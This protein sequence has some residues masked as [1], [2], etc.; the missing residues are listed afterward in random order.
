ML[1]AK[2]KQ[3]KM[4]EDLKQQEKVKQ[5]EKSLSL[6]IKNTR[7]KEGDEKQGGLAHIVSTDQLLIEP[8]SKGILLAEDKSNSI[9]NAKT[10]NHSPTNNILDRSQYTAEG[11]VKLED[12]RPR[13]P[14]KVLKKIRYESKEHHVESTRAMPQMH[15]AERDQHLSE[16]QVIGTGQQGHSSVLASNKKYSKSL[17]TRNLGQS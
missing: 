1:V 3:L 7:L 13:K 10:N 4:Q 6:K 16:I 15:S 17:K 2:N 12:K 14:S 11:S 5:N 8:G 9:L